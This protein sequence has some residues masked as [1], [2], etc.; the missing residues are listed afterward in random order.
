MR[1]RS[2][3]P[4]LV[5][6]AVVSACASQA[7][8][9]AGSPAP[10]PVDAD[11]V[12]LRVFSALQRDDIEAVMGLFSMRMA[13][14][15]SSHALRQTWRQVIDQN[16]TL[17]KMSVVRRD[18]QE[19]FDVRDLDLRFERG[20]AIGR[21]AVSPSTGEVEGLFLLPPEAAGGGTAAR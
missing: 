1:T 20:S 10:Q 14:A 19:G 12:S 8:A 17:K 7:A 16:G 6:A 3:F 11:A 2:S 15:L 4:L 5:A 18:R 21:V 13:G 9:P